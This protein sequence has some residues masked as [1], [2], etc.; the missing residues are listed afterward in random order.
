[1]LSAGQDTLLRMASNAA[2]SSQ[3]HD[4]ELVELLDAA[5]QVRAMCQSPGWELVQSLVKTHAD[6]LE[7]RMLSAS[8]P[9]YPQMAALAGE[10]RGLR[11]LGEAAETVLVEAQAR[12]A[13]EQQRVGA[14]HV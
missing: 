8:L 6:R 1:M 9:D 7:L 11:A 12:E 2:F 10:L 3:L 13:E 5:K 14:D 4:L